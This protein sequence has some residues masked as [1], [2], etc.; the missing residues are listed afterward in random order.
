MDARMET[1]PVA[2]EINY[3]NDLL[4]SHRRRPTTTRSPPPPLPLLSTSKLFPI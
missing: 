2:V 1:H 3:F 4:D